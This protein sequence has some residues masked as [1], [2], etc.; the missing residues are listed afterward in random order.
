VEVL[1]HGSFRPEPL[2][3]GPPNRWSD[4]DLNELGSTCHVSQFYMAS[5]RFVEAEKT[6]SPRRH[7]DTEKSFILQRG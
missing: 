6:L 5:W 1:A 7:R 3:F 4:V 2:R